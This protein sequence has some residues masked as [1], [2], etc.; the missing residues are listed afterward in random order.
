[1]GQ[2]QVRAKLSAPRVP[3]LMVARYSLLLLSGLE[4]HGPQRTGAYEALPKWRRPARWPSCQD[5][6]NPLRKQVAAQR[7]GRRSRLAEALSG[8]LRAAT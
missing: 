8:V 3:A 7:G 1:V 5:L 4:A 6:V 2:A